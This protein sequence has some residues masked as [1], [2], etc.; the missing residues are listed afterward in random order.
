MA[1]VKTP[2]VPNATSL[3]G[4]HVQLQTPIV[5]GGRADVECISSVQHPA[6]I[7]NGVVVDKTFS[8]DQH[9]WCFVEVI[10]TVDLLIGRFAGTA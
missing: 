8:T 9:N 6:G 7:D 5:L 1:W 2:C 4:W 10:R 3:G